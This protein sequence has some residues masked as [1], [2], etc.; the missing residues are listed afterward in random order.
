MHGIVDNRERAA[1]SHELRTFPLMLHEAGYQTAF[2]GKW[3]MGHDDDTSRPGFDRWVS[4]EGQ[5]DY[6]DADF[7]VDGERFTE[8]GY[9]TDI[10]NRYA[11]EFIRETDD[12]FLVYLSHKAVHPEIHPNMVRTFPAAPRHEGLY[13]DVEVPREPAA[14]VGTEGKPALER[15]I[16]FEDP[17]SG[18][19]PDEDILN[20]LRMLSAVDDGIGDLLELL[21]EKGKLE[22]TLF[23]FTSDQGF[24]YGEFGLGQ[25]RR[26]AYEPSIRIPFIVR[27]P[28]LVEA[29]SRPEVM[30]LNIDVAP[31]ILEVSGVPIP[32]DIQGKSL[33]PVFQ[34]SLNEDFREE[35][36]IEYYTDE[37]F[38]RI[39]KM[40]YK[41][42]RSNRYKYIQYTD[43]QGMN[44]FYDL[45]LDPFELDN[46]IDDP[47]YEHEIIKMRQYLK[48]YFEM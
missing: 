41:A 40:G 18:R 21:S 20:R 7:N 25:E 17:R 30:G 32:D 12:P 34:G 4:F 9:I 16:D 10:L 26:L 19:T 48:N 11:L 29:G 35:F 36:L 15:E 47:Q 42:I 45:K 6:I 3:H 8:S 43:L 38:P 33:I 14:S 13:E 44:E 23:I 2:I 1:E 46:R 24:F 37:V 31:T 27:Y 28:S 22:E 39:Y 5:G